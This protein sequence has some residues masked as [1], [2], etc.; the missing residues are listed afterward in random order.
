MSV[1]QSLPV[2]CVQGGKFLSIKRLTLKNALDDGY[3]ELDWKSFSPA[4]TIAL[5][6]LKAASLYPKALSMS[7]LRRLFAY[8]FLAITTAPF[9]NAQGADPA[10]DSYYAANALYNKQLYDLAIEEYRSFIAKFPRHEKILHAR[11]G[12][13]FSFYNMA[14]YR[15]AEQLLAELSRER[16]APKKEQIYNFWGQCLLLL[17]R[18]AEAESAFLWSV[19]RGRE[20]LFIDLPGMGTQVQESPEMAAASIQ[21]LDSI[22]RAMIGLIESVFQQGK[23]QSVIEHGNEF[24]RLIP[25]SQNMARI[26]FQTAFAMYEMKLYQPAAEILEDIKLYHKMSPFYEHAVFLL[27]ECQRETGNLDMAAR[28]H[29]IVAQEVK[30]DFAGSSLFR[31]GF[32]RFSQ[33]QWVDAA[34]AFQDL[35]LIYPNSE[36]FNEAGIYLGRSFLE[37][38]DF[39]RAQEVFG[40][41]TSVGPVA[42]EATLW[43]GRTFHRQN[44]HQQAMEI[45]GPAVRRFTDHALLNQFIFDYGLAL[46]GLGQNRDA[47]EV[48]QRVV[49][50]FD[51]SLLTPQALRLRAFAL[52]NDQRYSDSIDTADRFLQRYPND[53]SYRDV[54]FM[55]AESVFFLRRLDE[56]LRAYQQFIPWERR[57]EYTDEARFRII[58]IL[59]EQQ[60]WNESMDAILELRRNGNVQGEFFEQIDYIEGLTY[61]NLNRVDSAITSLDAFIR[62]GSRRLNADIAQIKLAQAYESKKDIQRAKAVLEIL[63]QENPTSEYI[64]QALSELGRINYNEGNIGLAETYFTRVSTEFSR[65]PF[66]PQSQ[67]F[68]GWIAMG[69]NN[70]LKA[71]SFFDRVARDFPDNELAADSLYK[72]ALLYLEMDQPANAEVAFK[73]FID[74]YPNNE[75]YDQATFYYGRS[76]ALVNRYREAASV[77]T[78]LLG[79]TRDTDLAARALY[80]VA[81]C[82]QGMENVEAAKA[83]YED[84]LQNYAAHP[85]AKR[86]NFE[87]AEIEYDEEKYDAAVGRLDVLMA[88]SL[89]DD[90]RE[91][92]IHRMA[93]SLLGRKQ[94]LASAEIFEQLIR[95]FPSSTFAPLAAY[96]AG[97]VRMARREYTLALPLF[98]RARSTSTDDRVKQQAWLRQAETLTFL[99]RWAEAEPLFSDFYQAYQTSE[100]ARRCLMWLGWSQENL[101]RFQQAISNYRLVLRGGRRDELSAR[102][103]FQIGQCLMNMGEYDQAVR[104]LILVDVNYAFPVWSARAIL[105]IGRVLDVQN[106][107]NEANNRFREV[108]LKY[109]DTPEADLAKDLLRERGIPLAQ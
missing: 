78:G 102:S 40:S 59:A 52:L 43:L 45:L 42:A 16:D 65:T 18:P 105:E 38:G 5:R 74:R 41:L 28:N 98:E 101:K 22:E 93:W 44:A 107:K 97:E 60:K 30:G 72:M 82:N 69:Q 9:L 50:E 89:E 96:Q 8:I 21:D 20:R 57:T 1:S 24:V 108:I 63:L 94:D 32:I 104:E 61:L 4:Y 3:S 83:R 2:Q 11:F 77:L 68:L 37:H 29:S 12:L 54:A 81:W 53:P 56:A 66:F 85:L 13:A 39:L 99:N 23:W 58:Q 92:V 64:G 73:N 91:K 31:L 33:R 36:Y 90:L 26:R 25:E 75:R 106:L 15:E 27:A 34:A 67:Y 49:N 10:L 14:R 88:Q 51:E 79:R 95:D 103:Q 84:L 76:L 35:R 19:N 62:G 17:G 80:E 47:A 46:V 70:Y 87:L 48:F 100:F 55:R 6:A 86:A 109:P 71:V 7:G